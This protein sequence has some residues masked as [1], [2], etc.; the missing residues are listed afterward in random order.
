M[1]YADYC[2]WKSVLLPDVIGINNVQMKCERSDEPDTGNWIARYSG[3]LKRG[4]NAEIL[5]YAENVDKFRI[6][7]QKCINGD[8]NDEDDWEHIC[9]RY[10]SDK[11]DESD[12]V[13][14]LGTVCTEVEKDLA[15]YDEPAEIET[16]IPVKNKEELKQKLIECF[17]MI[18]KD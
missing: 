16:G 13:K 12:A 17:D 11:L 4:Y 10:T 1:V 2:I 8:V 14:L 18:F 15:E 9:G 5:I 6:I 7:A 3:E